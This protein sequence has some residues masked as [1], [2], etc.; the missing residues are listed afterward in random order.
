M[1]MFEVVK[2]FVSFILLYLF[3]WM[4]PIKIMLGV[5]DYDLSWNLILQQLQFSNCGHLWFLPCLFIIFII[6][7]T[8]CWF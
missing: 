4:D 6:M 5:K 3:I 1:P 2:H 7:Y 8:F